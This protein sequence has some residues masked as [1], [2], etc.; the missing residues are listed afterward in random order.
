MKILHLCLASFYIDNYSYQENMLPKFHKK[1]GLDV[2]IIASL[3]SFDKN[4][5]VCLLNEAAEYVN[6][7]GIPVKRLNYKKGYFNRI[8]RKYE[9]T[10]ESISESN[11]DIIFVHGCQFLDVKYVI[12]YAEQNPNTKIYVDN[13]ADFSNSARNLL[14]KYFLHK[15]VWKRCAK[16]IEPFT[17]KFYGVLP[18]RVDFL[19]YVY[20]VCENKVELLVMGA[21]DEAINKI[22]TNNSK[23]KIRNRLGISDNEFLIVTGGKIDKAKMQVFQL[24]EAVKKLNRNDVKLIIFGSVIEELQDRIN[25][26]TEGV[27][28]QFVG[29]ANVMESYEYLYAADLVIFPGRHSVYWEQAVG[30]GVPM[31]VK[32][33]EGTTHVNVNGNCAFLYKD[34]TSEISDIILYYL[35]NPGEFN[36]IKKKALNDARKQF[37][38]SDIS[39]RSIEFS[40][41]FKLR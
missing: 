32:H 14:S 25:K 37:L 28:I 29:W 40:G 9:N 33:W 12:K 27:Q 5:K 2:E 17:E 1:F 30:V 6:E 24:I 22:H 20:G 11:P 16:R 41:N 8:F 7:Y 38:Y 13:H 39:R 34:N 3:V 19:K 18:A 15:I 21:D 10:F 31:V 4:G 35:N 36:R 23:E 26:E